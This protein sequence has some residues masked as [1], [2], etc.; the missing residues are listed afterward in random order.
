MPIYPKNALDQNLEGTVTLTI[1]V[2]SE[3]AIE[4]VVITKSSGY[5]ILDDAAIRAIRKG[6]A[7]KPGM[8]KGKLAPGKST[9]AF[10]FSAG[11]VK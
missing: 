10:E 2:G 1:S 6:W 4:A 11:A 3:G 9:I 8:M 5:K 7:F